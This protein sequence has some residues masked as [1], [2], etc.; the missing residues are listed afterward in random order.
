MKKSTLSG[1][2]EAFP[3]PNSIAIGGDAHQDES[4]PRLYIAKGVIREVFFNEF[5][6]FSPTWF[7]LDGPFTSS[8]FRS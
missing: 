1:V 3:S 7:S 2:K 8:E 6:S 4:S 5:R